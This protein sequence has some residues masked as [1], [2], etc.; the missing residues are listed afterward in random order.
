[1]K[2]ESDMTTKQWNIIKGL[3]ER[4]NRG[5]HLRLHSKRKLVNAVLY[6]NKTGCQWRQLPHDFPK[7]T[8]VSSF[9]QRAVKSGLWE[10]ILALLVIKSRV[11]AGRK[12]NPSYA[13]I[14]SQSVKTTSASDERGIDGGK[15][16]RAVSVTS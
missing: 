4:E 11:Q 13:L 3:F 9:Y 10:K 1:M 7:Y 14:D 5:K 15:K 12:P 6:L 16:R 2:Y 8:T